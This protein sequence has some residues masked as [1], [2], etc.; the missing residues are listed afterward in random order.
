MRLAATTVLQ[1]K[2]FTAV[3][4][5]V[6]WL[7]GIDRVGRG[8]MSLNKLPVRRHELRLVVWSSGDS[9]PGQV[10]F[11]VGQALGEAGLNV[12]VV[13]EGSSDTRARVVQDDH[14]Q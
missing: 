7:T 1:N 6:R 10:V 3:D 4:Q 2:V 5:Y 12:D 9:T 13:H 14:Q 8:I 11:S